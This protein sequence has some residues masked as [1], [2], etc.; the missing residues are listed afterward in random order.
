[1]VP[2]IITSRLS[3]TASCTSVPGNNPFSNAAA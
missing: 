2:P 3:I 1:V